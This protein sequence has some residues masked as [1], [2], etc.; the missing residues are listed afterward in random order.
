MT[1][2]HD[3]LVIHR[4]SVLGSLNRF[5]TRGSFMHIYCGTN[6]FMVVGNSPIPAQSTVRLGSRTYEYQSTINLSG[7][8]ETQV[9]SLM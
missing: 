6:I 3:R 5:K 4:S 1:H 7:N 2:F 9:D 8:L